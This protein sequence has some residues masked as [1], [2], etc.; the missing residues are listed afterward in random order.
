MKALF[1][2]A[3][4][5]GVAAATPAQ[6]ADKTPDVL[7]GPVDP[8][9]AA[10]EKV[11]FFA[12]AG[13]DNELDANEAAAA[14]AKGDSFVRKFDRWEDMLSFDKDR[15]KEI[16]WFEADAY[17][18]SLRA[19]VLKLYD[20]DGDGKLTGAERQK[21]SAAL[22]AGEI[23]AA[24]KPSDRPRFSV[25]RPVGGPDGGAG[26]GPRGAAG[27]PA[28]QPGGGPGR[29]F[30]PTQEDLKKYDKDGD[31]KL[32]DEERGEMFAGRMRTEVQKRRAE[33]YEKYDRNKDGRIDAEEKKAMLEGIEKEAMARMEE[34]AL[35]FADKD[36][37]G[38]LS[39]SERKTM[40]EQRDV[41]R[42][43]AEEWRDKAML[44][45]YD[46]DGDGKLSDEEKKTMETEQADRQ[47][48]GE[49][50]RRKFELK[51]FDLNGDGKLDEQEEVLRDA[52][53]ALRRS[54][55]GAP[56]GFGGGPGAN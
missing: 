17:R 21:A 39:E 42:K 16:D 49:E 22:A 12:A 56:G 28:S 10:G 15:S 7:N 54:F 36:G 14:A 25:A 35:R 51:I 52:A 23:P 33:V 27:G 1:F 2:F 3:M 44:R 11:K 4:L 41:W 47:K 45:R 30:Q 43:R 55:M 38:K 8:Y 31:G 24:P 34:F 26:P 29:M 48:Q 37:D 5:L 9:D 20:A 6:P 13:A 32:N 46:K 50:M 40:E 18:Q 53:N 19:R